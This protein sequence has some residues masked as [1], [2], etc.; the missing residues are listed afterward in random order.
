MK[1]LICALLYFSVIAAG[2]QDTI[3]PSPSD[4]LPPDDS[5]STVSDDSASNTGEYRR[6]EIFYPPD[7][8]PPGGYIIGAGDVLHVTCYT[9]ET[10]T[11]DYFVRYDGYDDFPFVG[12]TRADGIALGDFNTIL[13]E[14]L[15]E[16]YNSP[17]IIAE[18]KEYNS[19]RCYVLG[20]V[21]APGV[22][23]FS[24]RAT[25]LEIIAQAGGFRHTAAR[26]STML[27]RSYYDQPA[28]MRVDMEKVI[29]E[30]AIALNM[31]VMPGDIIVVP[32]TFIANIN[33]FMN[34]ITPSLNTYVRINSVY[35]TQ[36]ER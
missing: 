18:V 30:G 24:G 6:D 7:I 21:V 35:K 11:G 13:E 19:C 23:K 25:L 20:E 29:D 14:K 10:L 2:A 32:K 27:V 16:I 22:Y 28:V 17:E 36:W 8:V 12:L 31:F 5:G 26:A 15:G 9:M 1:L 33:E 4:S 34:D 3:S